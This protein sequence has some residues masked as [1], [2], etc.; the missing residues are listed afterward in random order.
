MFIRREILL[1]LADAGDR[2]ECLLVRYRQLARPNIADYATSFRVFEDFRR[3]VL[4]YLVH[5][6]NSDKGMRK[7][8]GSWTKRRSMSRPMMMSVTQMPTVPVMTLLSELPMP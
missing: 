2:A 7:M 8:K 3:T 5:L 6:T 1:A 4:Y